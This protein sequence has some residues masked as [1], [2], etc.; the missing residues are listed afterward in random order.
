[1]VQ[2]PDS[3]AVPVICTVDDQPLDLERWRTAVA[4]F[5][6]LADP[7]HIPQAELPRTATLKVKRIELSRRLQEQMEKQA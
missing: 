3:E 6:Q 2:G 1:V 7:V 5:P 4:D